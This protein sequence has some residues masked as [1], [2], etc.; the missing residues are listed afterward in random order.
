MEW[1]ERMAIFQKLVSLPSPQ[2][3]QF[4]FVVNPPP[5]I[6][7]PHQAAQGDR[8]K[9]LLD[10]AINR[11]PSL[12]SLDDIYAKV[13]QSSG[14]FPSL[15]NPYPHSKKHLDS[16]DLQAKG[17]YSICPSSQASEEISLLHEDIQSSGESPP[18]VSFFFV[19]C[20]DF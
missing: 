1:Q 6:I 17:E 13:V 3:E 8:V 2:F 18:L 10:W 15:E 11:E 19:Y 5:G 4:I 16:I 12:N 14:S 7:P 9:A 20:S